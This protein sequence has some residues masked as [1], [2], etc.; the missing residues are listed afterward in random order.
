[1]KLK[2]IDVSKH[3]GAINW[4]KVKESGI[5]GVII[6]AG[7]GFNNIDKYFYDNLTGAIANGLHIGI[8]WFGY[9]GTVAHAQSEAK[10]LVKVLS[11][12]KGQIDLPI[13]YDW[14][15]DS[16]NYIKKQYGITATKELVS[17]LTTAFCEVLESNGWF[18]GFYANI[19]YMNNYYTSTVKNRFTVWVAQWSSACTYT[20]QYSVWQYSDKGA[21][22]GIEGNGGKVDMDYLIKDLPSTIK[23]GGFNGYG[24]PTIDTSKYVY[25]VNQDGT[26]DEKDLTALKEYLAKKGL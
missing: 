13:Y 25:D 22:N 18:S 7:Y 6:R 21:V 1:M 26:V 20:G 10:Y 11:D 2:L 23:N 4:A 15:Y 19:D 12:Y 8:Y 3:N 16:Y 17:N 9:A 5:E 14:E 24:T